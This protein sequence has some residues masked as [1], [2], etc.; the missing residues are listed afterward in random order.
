MDVSWGTLVPIVVG[1]ALTLGSQYVLLR[2]RH[3]QGRRVAVLPETIEEVRSIRDFFERTSQLLAKVNSHI[4]FIDSEP[5]MK[6]V[7]GFR[8][9]YK[10]RLDPIVK[11]LDDEWKAS[12]RFP[13]AV[14]EQLQRAYSHYRLQIYLSVTT[15]RLLLEEWCSF[16]NTFAI[17]A[18]YNSV[19]REMVDALRR[20]LTE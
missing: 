17:S 8:E 5:Q 19:Y 3:R 20:E 16:S 9:T 6:E 1:S 18:S 11:Q 12:T 13:I 10:N 2:L 7:G 4:D 15:S 14:S